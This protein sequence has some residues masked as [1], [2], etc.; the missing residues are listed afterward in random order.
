MPFTKRPDSS[1]LYMRIIPPAEVGSRQVDWSL[2]RRGIRRDS[3]AALPY[4]R[5]RHR[6]RGQADAFRGLIP[7]WKNRFSAS[8]SDCA[9]GCQRAY[10]LARGRLTFPLTLAAGFH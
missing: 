9:T 2:S 3:A 6:F 10:D 7:E 5:G 4:G 1:A 8:R